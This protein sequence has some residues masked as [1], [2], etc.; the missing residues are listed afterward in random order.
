MSKRR[1]RKSSSRSNVRRQSVMEA[2][3]PRVLLSYT[4]ISEVADTGNMATNGTNLQA[5]L[6]SDAAHLVNGH[7]LQYGD[8]IVL[9]ANA[10]YLAPTG[11]FH[12]SLQAT[13]HG[14]DHHRVFH[15]LDAPSTTATAVMICP[16]TTASRTMKP[17]TCPSSNRTAATPPVIQTVLKDP[18]GDCRHHRRSRLR[19]GWPGDLP[20]ERH[21]RL[22][23]PGHTGRRHHRPKHGC[24]RSPRHHHRSLLHSRP[25]SRQ[26]HHLRQYPAWRC[27]STVPTPPSRTAKS[28]TSSRKLPTPRPSA[29][30]TAQATS[31]STTTTSKAPPNASSMAGPTA[32]CMPTATT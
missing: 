27:G 4:W 3:E 16:P 2:L 11:W 24:L 8:T 1:N 10:T 32:T 12:A 29:E 21:R 25:G 23:F 14:Q 28:R 5:V 19:I 15:D 7:Y 13:G 30:A 31:R 17:S 18:H 22:H 26:R 20:R 6:N 9:A